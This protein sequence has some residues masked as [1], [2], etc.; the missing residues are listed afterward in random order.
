MSRTLIVSLAAVS[1]CLLVA[2]RQADAIDYGDKLDLSSVGTAL[3]FDGDPNT[4]RHSPSVNLASMNVVAALDSFETLNEIEDGSS[5]RVEA[6]LVH[7][8]YTPSQ[9]QFSNFSAEATI[10]TGVVIITVNGTEYEEQFGIA[11][12]CMEMCGD[13]CVDKCNGK[14]DPQKCM[15]ACL[16]TCWW[17]C[18][19]LMVIPS[20]W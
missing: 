5:A 11:S 12:D 14:P 6:Y 19:W 16:A 8:G 18:G 2:I 10:E 4:Y 13:M 1:L 3:K 20:C 7:Y 15:N 9:I 17:T